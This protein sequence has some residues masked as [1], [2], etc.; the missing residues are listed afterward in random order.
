MPA[1]RVPLSVAG[2]GSWLIWFTAAVVY[3]LAVFH[4]TSLG[5]AGLEA[6]ERFGIGPAALSSFTVLQ[7]AVY[8]TMQVP[9]GVLVDRFGPRRVLTVAAL[10]LGTGQVL[11]AV[12]GS[13]PL[14]LLARG[15][16]GLG[17][18]LTFISVLRLAANHFP[19]R[20]YPIVATLTGALGFA[21][22]LAATVPLALL[23]GGPG[24]IV[25]FLFAGALTLAYAA[26]VQWRVLDTPNTRSQPRDERGSLSV[27]A[28]GTQVAQAWSVPGTRV[29]FWTHFSTMF[30]PMVLKLLW[31]VP[32]L[33]EAQG[34]GREQ[35]SGII[36]TLVIAAMV[37]GPAVGAIIGRWPAARMVLVVGYLAGA[38][39]TWSVLLSW[40]GV[41]PLGVLLPC[42]AFLALGGPVSTVGFALARDYNP[43][44]RVGTATGVVNMGGFVA[45]TVAALA[46]GVVLELTGGNYRLAFLAMVAMLVLAGYRLLV[47][48]LRA[49]AAVLAAQARG[50]DVPVLLRKRL[51]DRPAPS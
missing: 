50:D 47:W 14:A 25:T 7:L 6:A 46:I 28:I 23:L 34:R 21:G 5:V 48:L 17:D 9:T 16:L 15:V 31:G 29:G 45:T 10:L 19:A 1:Q 44:G 26:M 43:I 37:T 22:N 20:Q 27:R 51:W 35:A 33:V 30:A 39:V 32:F 42:F 18:A 38:V 24:W 41:V 12:A 8:A 11:I 3:V 36:M 40:S 4:R 49:R 13:Y 2:A